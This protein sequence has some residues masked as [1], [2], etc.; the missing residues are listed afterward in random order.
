MLDFSVVDGDKNRNDLDRRKWKIFR[1]EF[2]FISGE[3][4]I[5]NLLRG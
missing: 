4:I 2:V 3:M 5:L 1:S